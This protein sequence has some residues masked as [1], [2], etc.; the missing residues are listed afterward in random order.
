MEISGPAES[1]EPRGR[2]Q[3]PTNSTGPKGGLRAPS[4]SSAAPAL[5]RARRRS[6]LRRRC[7]AR[8]ARC[9]AR[10]GGGVPRTSP[11]GPG[12]PRPAPPRARI[13][14]ASAAPP[15]AAARLRG[16]P[17]AP[18]R[19][20][21]GGSALRAAGIPSPVPVLRV[22]L[23]RRGGSRGG[24]ERAGRWAGGEQA[25]SRPR[26]Q[27]PRSRSAMAAAGAV[28]G[29]LAASLPR[30]CSLRAFPAVTERR[31]GGRAVLRGRGRTPPGR[32]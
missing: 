30:A 26:A 31:A 15:A 3:G 6:A 8:A 22:G 1:C 17:A 11:A 18:R 13:G 10:R 9:L 2:H 32:S 23:W 5:P 4:R 7:L 29:R 20:Q 16:D 21:P 14:A 24:G 27:R 12:P 25:A 28:E 19:A